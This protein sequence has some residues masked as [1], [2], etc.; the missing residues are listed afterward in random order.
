MRYTLLILA[1]LVSATLFGQDNVLVE[2]SYWKKQP[3]LEKVKADIAAGNDPA[4]FNKHTF[5]AVTWAILENADAEI[6]WHLLHLEGNGV[7]KRSHD[8]R[9]PIFWA[10]Y[11][12]NVPLMQKLIEK[13]AKTDLIDSHG[14]SLV[15][16]AATTGQMNQAIYD[17]CLEQGADF[18]KERN[19]DGANPIH[20]IVPFLKDTELIS[21]FEKHG[22]DFKAKD[23]HGNNAFVYAAK[24]GNIAMMQYAQKQ[25]LDPHANKDAAVIFA[26]KGTRRGSVSMEGYKFLKEQGL[27]LAISDD[28]GHDA[29]YYLSAKST[30]MDILQLFLNAGLQPDQKDAEGNCAFLRAATYNTS[31]VVELLAKKTKN[32]SI[33]NSKGENALH[34]AANSGNKEN[35]QLA[36]K[37]GIPVNEVT[38]E[39][40]SALHLVAMTAKD[41][42]MLTFLMEQGADK[43][44]QTEF[45][46]T[47][48]DLASENELLQKNNANLEF[49]KP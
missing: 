32:V 28:K 6:V 17:L 29:L 30:D 23:D 40:M 3:S 8:G 20:L 18:S 41:T 16:F 35:V 5:D 33:Q 19:N 48:F 22:V 42:E 25:G 10:A 13:G 36:L 38:K 21:Y 11:K 46:E 4:A 15:N 43:S 9:T 31:E 27:S 34:L 44:L 14:Y 47:A 49:L 1:T 24:T 37:L 2:R 12:N 7:N 39:K 26:S 45:G